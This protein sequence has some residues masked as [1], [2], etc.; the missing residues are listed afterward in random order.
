MYQ[1]APLRL[2]AWATLA[3]VFATGCGPPSRPR[4]TDDEPVTPAD[5]GSCGSCPEPSADA[6]SPTACTPG[7]GTACT[8][9]DGRLG[10]ATCVADGSR[11]GPCSCDGPSVCVAGAAAACTCEGGGAGSKQC[12]SSGSAYGACACT[13]TPRLQLCVVLPP[14]SR[15]CWSPG[16]GVSPP[17]F[18]FGDVQAGA[19]VDGTLE[20]TNS[21]S[22]TLEF[23]ATL[24]TQPA[25]ALVGSPSGRLPTAA[26][27]SVTVR[28]ASSSAGTFAGDVNI[29]SND[30]TAGVVAVAVAGRVRSCVAS[31]SGKLCGDDGCGGV[32]GTCSSPPATTCANAN[33]L[34]TFTSGAS[35]L[36]GACV[37]SYGDTSCPNGCSAGRCLSCTPSCSGKQCGS[38]GCGGSCGGCATPPPAVCTS[39]TVLTSSAATGSCSSAGTCSYA[40]SS[41]TCAQGC[42][43]GA[44]QSC[45]ETDLSLCTRAGLECGQQTFLNVCGPGLSRTV[46]CGPCPGSGSC[47]S[48][49][50]VC[51][52]SEKDFCARTGNRCGTTTGI[53][54]CGQTRSVNCGAAC[55]SWALRNAG[56]N[57][58]HSLQGIWGASETDLW[59]VGYE[60]STVP[61]R[62]VL[63]HSDGT[64]PWVE[65]ALPAGTRWLW[66]IRGRA[67]ND[68]WATGNGGTIV[69]YDGN[70]WSTASFGGDFLHDSFAWSATNAFAVGQAGR[71]LRFDGTTWTPM[72]NPGPGLGKDWHSVWVFSANDAWVAGADGLTAHFDGSIWTP[73]QSPVTVAL[74]DLWGTGTTLFATGVGSTMLRFGNGGWSVTRPT[75]VADP[76]E[77]A[78]AGNAVNNVWAAGNGSSS[79]HFDGSTWTR[80]DAPKNPNVLKC[81]ATNVEPCAVALHGTWVAPSGALWVAGWDGYVARRAP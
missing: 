34:R 20:V 31:C 18:Q 42:A 47:V 80:D 15:S 32:C 12:N 61:E 27:A 28:F 44:C 7:D 72:P 50:C 10:Q 64:N 69:H 66:S 63:Y 81:G 6:G 75:G 57:P 48:G 35:C 40:L 5:A 9:S 26:S 71:I 62:G 16:T 1:K 41:T 53:D 23:T 56:I 30:S 76:K 59:A 13:A 17:S 54:L 79:Y 60:I 8:C 3:L 37:Y 77:F 51:S 38:D 45:T 49:T 78:V 36:S 39:A 67:A 46:S 33:T 24:S 21:G 68:V 55:G 22:G 74:Q 4:G 11:Y 52:E 73:I 70:G 19:S 14:A 25:F 2:T 58:K 29:A 65:V 43:N